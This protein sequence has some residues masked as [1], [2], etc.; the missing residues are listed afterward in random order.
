MSLFEP[1][2]TTGDRGGFGPRSSPTDDPWGHEVGEDLDHVL[3]PWGHH[4][5]HHTEVGEAHLLGAP[6]PVTH[7]L[8]RERQM[9]W[10]I[11]LA[12]LVVAGSAVALA[13]TLGI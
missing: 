3:D 5:L 7:P 8:T 1:N 13:L 6:K 10:P 12:V 9:T 4:R 2:G 11:V